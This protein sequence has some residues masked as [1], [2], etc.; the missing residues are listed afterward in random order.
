MRKDKVALIIGAGDYLGS[1]IAR[2]FA[3]EGFHAVG[4]RRRGDISSFVKEIEDS[5]GKAT[6]MHSDARNE[7]QVVKLIE[8]VENEIGTIEVF[9]FNIG[10]N[11]KFSIL[12]TTTRVYTKVWEMCSLAGFLTGREIARRMVIRKRGT[13]LYTGATASVRGGSGFSAFAGGK[14][15]LRALA[16]S[17][18]KELMPQNIHVAHVIIDGPIDTEWTRQRFPDMVKERPVDGLLQPDD[19][20]ETY[21]TIHNQKRSAW[22]FET[23]LRP[24][25]EPW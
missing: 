2:R 17:M 18:A 8:S 20:A 21:W 1:S 4:T 13:M 10:G 23:D 25:I 12:D 14:H 3:K 9:V 11:V 22:T 15:A 5:G 19:I 6:G 24:W 16:Q 7:E